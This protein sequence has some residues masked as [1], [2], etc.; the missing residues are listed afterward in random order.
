MDSQFLQRL[1][2]Q[3][4]KRFH[5]LNS[6]SPTLFHSSLVQFWNY[7]RT[8]PLTAGILAKLDAEAS[9]YTAE[10]EALT[11]RN[12]VEEFDDERKQPGYV[13]RIIE[14]CAMKAR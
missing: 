6:C 13:Y 5:R 3:L 2:F 10:V 8:Q 11:T 12:V 7:L 1:R 14:Y 9:L 4:Q